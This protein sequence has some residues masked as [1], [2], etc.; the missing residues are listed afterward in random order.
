MR[1]VQLG[2][3]GS[4]L[5]DPPTRPSGVGTAAVRDLRG[6]QLEAVT[7]AL[8]AVNTSLSADADAG[9]LTLSLTSATGVV[10]GRRYLV[11]GP[12]AGGGEW[13]TIRA[14]SGTTATLVRRLQRARASGSGFVGTRLTFAVTTASTAAPGRNFRVEWTSPEGVVTPVPFDVT[15]YAPTSALTGEELRDLDPAFFARVSA[16]EWLPGRVASAWEMILR[17]VSQQVAPGALIG[18][19]DLTTAHGYLVRALLA[20][21]FGKSDEARAELDDLRRRYAQERDAALAACAYD[22]RQTGAA[23][24]ARGFYRRIQL[25]RG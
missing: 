14:L 22:E 2:A 16:G 4:V 25:V 15:R 1:W 11:G 20:E 19:V 10:A 6:G 13:V 18:M 3:A 5:L 17:H 24:N 21:S 7:P 12:E 23:S 9:A 8:D